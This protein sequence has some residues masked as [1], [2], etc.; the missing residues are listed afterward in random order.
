MLSPA[1]LGSSKMRGLVSAGS[2]PSFDVSAPE[3]KPI[4][5]LRTYFVD[6]TLYIYS[7]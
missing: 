7:Q 3:Y 1:L 5:G 2:E 6:Q 4:F